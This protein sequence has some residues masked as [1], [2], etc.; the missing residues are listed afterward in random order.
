MIGRE[1]EIRKFRDRARYFNFVVLFFLC[2]IGLRLYVLQ[3]AQ[4]EE[5]RRYSEANRLKKEKLQPTR[6]IIYDREGRVIVD[7]R[8]S[9]DV[10]MLSQYYPF[11]KEVNDRLFKVLGMP[12]AEFDRRLQKAKKT[13]SFHAVLLKSDVSKDVIAGIEMDPEEFPGV[14]IEASVQRKYPYGEMSAQA[15]GYVGEVNDR[16]IKRYTTRGLEPGDYIGK[17]GLE[18]QYDAYLRGVNGAGYVEVDARGRRR[19]TEQ[20]EKLLGFEAQTEPI[21]GHDLHL[22]LDMDLESAALDA[23][24]SREYYGSVVAIDPRNGEILAMINRPSYDPEQISGRE[25]SSKVWASLANDPMRPLRN[26]AIQDHYPPG[27]TYKLLVAIAAL[28]EGHANTDTRINCTGHLYFGGRRYHCWKRHGTVDIFKA[29][30]ESCDVFFYKMGIALGVDAMAKYS[31]AFGLGKLTGIALPDE[32][33]G[34]IPDSVWKEKVF[35]EPWQ[36]GENLSVAIGQG[37]V[38]STPIQLANAYA[39]IGNGG[40]VYKPLLVRRVVDRNGDV[41]EEFKPEL[42]QK[43]DVPAEIFDIVKEGLYKVVNERGGTAFWHRSRM[44]GY[45]GK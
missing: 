5:L 6:G 26:R 27:S 23:L 43:V 2:I 19:Q 7:N 11:T 22:T 16:E 15:L 20:G 24:V 41:I 4:G 28:A 3:I 30:K 9:F 40:F 13:R 8:A 38:V 39:A 45:S 32:I 10:V 21:P 31:R 29:I 25:V 33:K 36:P 1:Q 34:I 17:V 42:N 44:V 37:F 18:K 35:K 14:Y 12:R